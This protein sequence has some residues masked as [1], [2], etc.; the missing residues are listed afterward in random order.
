MNCIF[1]C[2]FNEEKY[3][4]M[5][6]LLLESIIIY[7]NLNSDT[8]ILIYTSSQFMNKITQ[9]HLFNEK[10]K[11]EIND[12]NNTIK[13]ACRS[14]YNI[15]D[16]KT[17][18]NYSK[19]LYLDTDI[20]IKDDL[21]QIFELINEDIL[22]VLEEGTIDNEFYGNKLFDEYGTKNNYKDKSAFT[23][24]ILLFNNCEK[25]KNLFEDTKKIICEKDELFQLNDQP[26]LV[27]NAFKYNL[28]NNKILKSFAVNNDK[29]INSNKVIHHFPGG[30]T[31]YMKK[32]EIMTNYLN[33][34]KKL[35]INM[36]IEITK[37]YIDE[38]QSILYPKLV[39]IPL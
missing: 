12:D 22:Y 7:G 31:I 18:Q 9:S 15:F 14:R 33:D 16:L 24:G 11:F 35:K 26:Y 10:I 21:N 6:Y 32:I 29:N 1:V 4:D 20:L 39:I 17:I 2:I 30:R 28:Y 38:Y 3:I 5:F 25:I 34:I 23:S 19:I 27:Y 36:N 8:E 37:K 13:S